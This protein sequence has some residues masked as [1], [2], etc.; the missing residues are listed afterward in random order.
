[1]IFSFTDHTS[2]AELPQQMAKLM[3]M[4]ENPTTLAIGTR[5]NTN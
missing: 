2:F 5:Y 1:M 3:K 4:T